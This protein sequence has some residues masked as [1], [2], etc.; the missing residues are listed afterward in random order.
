[1]AVNPKSIENL[2][3]GKKSGSKSGRR[4]CIDTL[5]KLLSIAG[6]QTKLLDDLQD[7]FDKSPSDFC[8]KYVFPVLPK[9]INLELS[10]NDEKPLLISN[11]L[12]DK[13]LDMPTD[14]LI[15]ILKAL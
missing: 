1:M 9:D 14:E 5:D 2:K 8:L 3:P 13:L 4:K 7:K 10:G 12:H 6:N 11:K 15:K